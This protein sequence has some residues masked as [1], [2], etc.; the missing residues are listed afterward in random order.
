MNPLFRAT[1]VTVA[2]LALVSGSDGSSNIVVATDHHNTQL[3]RGNEQ[4][5]G[6]G[7]EKT[8]NFDESYFDEDFIPPW[9]DAEPTVPVITITD[10]TPPT[11]KPPTVSPT[12]PPTEPPTKAPTEPPTA[13][14]V[15]LATLS[16]T[17]SPTAMPVSSSIVA[18]P[19]PVE[20]IVDLEPEP[21]AG[22]LNNLDPDAVLTTTF[23]EDSGV[24]ET[25]CVLLPS[26]GNLVTEVLDIEYFL[27]L[28]EDEAIIDEETIQG[29][30]DS[31]IEP[32]LHDA[33]VDIGM[34]CN[35][36]DFV[37]GKHVMVDLSSSGM[38][39][40][41]AE[42]SIDMV[43]DVLR[44][45]VTACYQVWGQVEATMWFAPRRQRQRK[46]NGNRH[47]QGSTTTPFGDREAYNVFTEWMEQAI[48]SLAGSDTNDSDGETG[49]EVVK[50]SFQGFVNVNG[51]DGTNSDLTEDINIDLTAAFMGTAW[52]TDDGG[53]NMVFGLVA[54]IAGAMVLSLVILVVV[55][56]RKKSR[57]A[58]LEHAQCIEEL[59][60]DSKDDLTNGADLVDD[61]S[62]FREDRPLP[63]DFKYKLESESHDYRWIGEERKN[64]IFVSTE[65]NKEFRDHLD[66]LQ[67]KK[68]QEVRAK[69]YES[70][71]L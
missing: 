20:A 10:P 31:S 7:A 61:E 30:V 34:G 63:E 56:R 3:H 54:I 52:T 18:T 42:C 44:S 46:L 17:R 48:D 51:F 4:F 40:I 16:P 70:V 35:S 6:I 22:A 55:I 53:I 26:I 49:V 65:R 15:I 71:M 38:D 9:R 60:L 13:K 64:P 21:E 12:T 19:P 58:F 24:K 43:D 62:L 69:Q 50:A 1:T 36:V 8:R 23:D 27:Y 45:N 59:A 32:R 2:T 28:N 14:P 25:S 47:L 5:F 39:L 57:K 66:V 11:T 68:E 33:L 37:T 67:R 41:G 29:I